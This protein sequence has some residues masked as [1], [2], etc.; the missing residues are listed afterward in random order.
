MSDLEHVDFKISLSSEWFRLPPHVQISLDDELIEDIEVAEKSSASEKQ[1]LEFSRDLGDGKHYLKIRY[2]GKEIP[3]TQIDANNNITKDHLINIDSI[4]IDDI[5]LGFL[6]FQKGIFYPDQVI[7]P[8]LPTE[9]HEMT[10][11]GY[12]GTWVLEF[13]VPTYIW[14][15]ENL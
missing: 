5:E 6:A 14:F 9:I 3:D 13:E 12:N 8:D 7:R 2:L 15:L 1:T 11:I 10:C 4:D